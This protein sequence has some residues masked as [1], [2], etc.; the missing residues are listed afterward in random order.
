MDDARAIYGKLVG[1]SRS[2]TVRRN[3]LQLLQG[4]DMTKQLRNRVNVTIKPVL[5][6]KNMYIMSNNLRAGLTNEW[7]DYKKKEYQPLPMLGPRR[8]GSDLYK[9]DRNRDRNPKRNLNPNPN[10]NPNLNRT[11]GYACRCYLSP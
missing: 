4:L 9:V 6:P 8:G 3:A 2:S 11:G 7:A 10:P 1:S 5:D